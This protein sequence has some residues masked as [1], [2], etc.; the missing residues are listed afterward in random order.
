[1]NTQDKTGG[2]GREGKTGGGV[3]LV[4]YVLAVAFV[5]CVMG[6]GIL[7]GAHPGSDWLFWIVVAL[8]TVM[9]FFVEAG[10]RRALAAYDRWRW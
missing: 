9:V 3:K 8:E 10:I 7:L 5:L 2:E 4:S 6:A 1:M